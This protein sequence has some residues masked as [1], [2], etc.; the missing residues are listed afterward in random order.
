MHCGNDLEELFFKELPDFEQNSKIF[1]PIIIGTVLN[2]DH[3]V[4]TIADLENKQFIYIDPRHNNEDSKEAED[5]RAKCQSFLQ[6][7]G[8]STNRNFDGKTFHLKSGSIGH[9][10]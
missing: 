2:G 9:I 7:Y 10:R 8:N 5:Y 6:K 4:L 1:L 3:W